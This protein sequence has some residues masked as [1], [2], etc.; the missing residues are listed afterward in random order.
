M[1]TSQARRFGDTL[2]DRH[3][4]TREA[5]E[6]ALELAAHSGESF[7]DVLT[8]SGELPSADVAAGWAAALGVAYVDFDTEVVRTDAANALTETVARAHGIAPVRM[9][10][11][12]LLVAFQ[13]PLDAKAVQAVSEHLRDHG[14][15]ELVVGISDADGVE[16]ALAA[17]YG[18]AEPVAKGKT[19]GE[20]SAEL[21][22][23]FERVLELGGSDLHLAAG[24]PPFVR[25]VGD[26]LRMPGEPELSAARIREMAYSILSLRQQQRFEET[27]ELDTSHAMGAKV[28][29]RV[30]VFVQR[31]A[32]G[33]AFRVIPFDV[34]DFSQLG[35]PEIVRTF[36]DLPRGLVLVTGPTGSGKS[37]TLASLID[38][39]NR[40]RAV[41]IMTIEDPVEFV[42][43]S[44]VAL[45]NQREVGEDT[46][47][48]GVAL[49]QA[50]REDPDVI[51][52][53]EMR[54]LDTIST[55]ITA[56]ETGH[57]VFGTLH[58]Q[59]AAQ[60][61]DRIIDV[62]PGDQQGQVRIQLANSLVGVTTQQL[63][64]TADGRGRAVACEVMIAN[65]AIRALIR[66]GKV[67]QIH[68]AMMSG[69]RAGMVSM[70]DSL[71]DLVRRG[72]VNADQAM[73]RAKNPDDLARM[74]GVEPTAP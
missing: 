46:A 5:V 35:V 21:Y 37:T 8:R 30:N 56:A 26:L 22:R 15:P 9:T 1:L 49:T 27:N 39:V 69:K 53:G 18:G 55:A 66:D 32:V 51:L 59:D 62:F 4:V 41:H 10:D 36:A 50:M 16:S 19:H 67:H 20:P 31:N 40:T 54:D 29:F 44:K 64:P 28:R 7:P 25:V 6:A 48:F 74:I 61:V 14:G 73:R 68:N 45:I 52:V 23:L 60:T 34:I 13:A 11:E 33:V 72:I 63:V 38:I 42:H 12:G 43:R 71:A 2:V 65:S 70:D 3:I 57:L 17:A 47:S 24:Q 58:T